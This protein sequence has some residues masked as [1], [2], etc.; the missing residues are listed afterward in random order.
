MELTAAAEKFIRRMMRFTAAAEAGFRLKAAPGGCS[1]LSM[2]FDLATEPRANEVVW[3]KADLRVFLDPE[4]SRLLDGA[5]VDFS[6]TLAQTGF[7]A[8]KP[9]GAEQCRSQTQAPAM[10]P[11]GAL[12]RS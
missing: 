9:G 2:T 4:S 1:G 5:V 3:T 10:V 7:V 6:E 11:V 8:L 12:L